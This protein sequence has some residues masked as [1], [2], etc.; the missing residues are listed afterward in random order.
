MGLQG[1]PQL[2]Q[3]VGRA[4]SLLQVDH[5]RCTLFS[6]GL[7]HLLPP[8]CCLQES[9]CLSCYSCLPQMLLT[10]CRLWACSRPTSLCAWS[11][12]AGFHIARLYVPGQL[13]MQTHTPAASQS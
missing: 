5:V 2:I 6:S 7:Y 11:T 13:I 8:A 4:S 10:C 3:G 9:G 1:R 12:P